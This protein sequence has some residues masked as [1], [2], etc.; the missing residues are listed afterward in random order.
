[1][2]SSNNKPKS[3][4]KRVANY[5]SLHIYQKAEVLVII[6]DIFCLAG[7]GVKE[8]FWCFSKDLLCS[9]FR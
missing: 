8:S 1:M 4:F 5:R 6:T 3:I 9:E 2:P 7:I